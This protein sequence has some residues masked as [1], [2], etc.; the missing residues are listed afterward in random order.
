[1]TGIS[2]KKDGKIY[3][4]TAGPFVLK[5]GD[6]VIVETE[7]GLAF[8]TVEIPP[9]LKSIP[10]RKLK[11]V[12][13]IAQPKDIEKH[14]T[15]LKLEKQAFDFCNKKIEERGLGMRLVDVQ[16]FFDGSK[17]TFFFT[18]N[19]RVDFRELI[20]D[21]TKELKTRI[22]LRQIGVRN[23]AKMVGGLGI[24]G[25][26]ICCSSYMKEFHII[27][28]K[29]AKEQNLSMNPNKISGTCGRLLCCLRYEYDSYCDMKKGMPKIGKTVSTPSG[30]GK[31][32]RQNILQDKI[33]VIIDD[34]EKEFK[35]CEIK[36]IQKPKKNKMKVAKK[37]EE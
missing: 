33:T 1:M 28:I 34:I 17:I 6:Y 29:M 25:R 3:D 9:R 32:I 14:L 20:K 12:Y 35:V 26:E 36:H 8:G 16:Y 23:Q 2:F 24:C 27:S 21:L 5:K 10:E 37:N 15:N 19:S 31:V 18:A 7:K 4:F 11:P 22:E 30:D 13:R